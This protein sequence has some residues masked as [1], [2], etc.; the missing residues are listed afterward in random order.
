MAAQA[1][2]NS[3][4]TL[5]DEIAIL[6][7][8]AAAF[9]IGQKQFKDVNRMLLGR[10]ARGGT[11]DLNKLRQVHAAMIDAV[12]SHF[13]RAGMAGSGGANQFADL[14]I[15]QTLRLYPRICRQL[16]GAKVPGRHE[17]QLLTAE[18][19]VP[20]AFALMNWPSPST[21]SRII[22]SLGHEFDGPLS[23]YVPPDGRAFCAVWERWLRVTGFRT[24][25]GFSKDSANMKDQGKRWLAGE[26]LPSIEDI[27]RTVRRYADRVAWLDG[28]DAWKARLRLARAVQYFRR[29]EE[30]ASKLTGGRLPPTIQTQ[31]S[32]INDEGILRDPDE[33]LTSPEIFFA[34]RLVQKRLKREGSWDRA[35]R[36]RRTS[37]AR[38]F[39]LRVSDAKIAE[40]RG[41]DLR[42][43]APGY[44][45]VR[46]L[47]R[48]GNIPLG[49]AFAPLPSPS[50]SRFE[51]YVIRLGIEELERLRDERRL[52]LKSQPP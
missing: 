21:G 47:G 36:P 30:K 1:T 33:W 32:T 27:D 2:D 31:F 3:P 16:C 38:H 26:T 51:A 11:Q 8:T 35:T 48:C 40:V 22:A 44:Q 24:P 50:R 7:T 29:E 41:K 20:T 9:G 43:I 12:L 4:A 49:P 46:Y 15:M 34:V 10:S 42:R 19:L 14:M 37:I 23:W 28:S 45:L 6:R 25:C 13:R 5:A 18:V 17:L 52:A 39:S